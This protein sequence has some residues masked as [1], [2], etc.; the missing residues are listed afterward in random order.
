M[1]AVNSIPHVRLALSSNKVASEQVRT[2]KSTL[3][4]HFDYEPQVTLHTLPVGVSTARVEFA[5]HS[6]VALCRVFNVLGE[7]T[8]L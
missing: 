8:T 6:D 7:W 3:R 1:M 5:S 2:I 4:K